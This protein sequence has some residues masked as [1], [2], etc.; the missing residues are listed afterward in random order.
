MQ[1]KNIQCSPHVFDT[2]RAHKLGNSID[3]VFCF[4]LLIPQRKQAALFCFI[5]VTVAFVCISSRTQQNCGST[6]ASEE[7]LSSLAN[8]LVRELTL[9]NILVLHCFQHS[10]GSFQAVGADS[11]MKRKDIVA[12]AKGGKT[13][14]ARNCKEETSPN[15]PGAIDAHWRE[16][17]CWLSTWFVPQKRCHYCLT[18]VV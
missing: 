3:D 6:T 5:Y 10:K 12:F 8:S 4:A 16:S 15:L 1:S 11:W 7:F 14:E 2:C 18:L 17:S 9:A 13:G